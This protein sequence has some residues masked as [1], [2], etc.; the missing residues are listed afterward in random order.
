MWA[1]E[2]TTASIS[3]TGRGRPRFF[4][5]ASLRLPWN[6]PQ[7]RTIARPF[8]R[9]R[10]Q[11]PVTSRAAPTKVISKPALA[12]D[13]GATLEENRQALI[14]LRH[15]RRL[16]AAPAPFVEQVCESVFIF[17]RAPGELQHHRL[18]FFHGSGK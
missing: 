17:T 18:V 6:M 4:L 8:T 10:W 12:F 16:P 9:S 11:E 5:S 2:R 15:Q 3:D 13:Y 14:V 1:C 7:S